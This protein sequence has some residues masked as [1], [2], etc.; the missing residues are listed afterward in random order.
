MLHDLDIGFLASTLKPVFQALGHQC[1]VIQ[2]T[3]TY[4]DRDNL[5]HV[6][7]M[8]S[9]HEDLARIH[10]IFKDTDFFIIRAYGDA[11]L[12]AVDI[13]HYA[14]RH[15][16]IFKVHG[17]ELRYTDIPYSL[18]TWRIDWHGREPLL[19]GS[20]DPSLLPHYRQ[21]VFTHIERPC[22][23]SK[24]PRKNTVSP[25]F[26]ITTPTNPERKGTQ[27][28]ID[29][30][31]STS[32]PLR[33]VSG[34]SRTEAL[35]EKSHA[36]YCIDRLGPDIHGPYNM[37]SVEAWLLKIPVFSH[38]THLDVASVPELPDLIH[39]VDEHTIQSTIE[40]YIPDKQALSR[41]YSY[42]KKTHNPLSI[43]QQ[44]LSLALSLA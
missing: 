16:A 34:V 7:I 38:Y 28:L 33:V 15:N 30:W 19:C 1:T 10:E 22:D 29:N 20:R 11:L 31:K 40:S 32:I 23:M 42:A 6:D 21:N 3:P 2:S 43:A 5:K 41:A 36:S 25:P 4:L 17:G 9:S 24:I 14:D 39:L 8:F 26:A 18:K 27:L 12:H 35:Q 13:G 37:N 44:Y